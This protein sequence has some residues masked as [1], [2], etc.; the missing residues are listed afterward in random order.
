MMLALLS[1]PAERFFDRL[2]GG[3]QW[4]RRRTGGHWEQWT[5]EPNFQAATGWESM[6]VSYQWRRSA[7]CNAGPMGQRPTSAV[8]EPQCEQYDDAPKRHL[9][10]SVRP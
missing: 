7:R 4:Y 6:S 8:G 5:I 9:S 1:A 10:I 3:F 2:L